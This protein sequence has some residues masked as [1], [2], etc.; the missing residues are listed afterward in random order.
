MGNPAEIE[1]KVCDME[2]EQ[3]RRG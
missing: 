1:D 3:R 2:R